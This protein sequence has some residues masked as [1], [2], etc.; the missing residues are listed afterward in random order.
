[1][2]AATL[3]QLTKLHFPWFKIPR[4]NLTSFFNIILMPVSED[5]PGIYIPPPLVYAAI[6]FLSILLQHTWPLDTSFFH[7]QT[8]TV[9]GI[10]FIIA[11]VLVNVTAIRQFVR[12]KNTIVTIKPANS[13]QTTG[14]YSRT[15]NPMYLGLV[16]FYTG[17]ALLTGNWWTLILLPF[18]VVVVGYSMIRPEE[19]YLER[20]FGNQFLEYKNKVRRWI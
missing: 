17:L 5:S 3:L 2:V 8:A 7:T 10:I 14:I 18:L 13:L 1:L 4:Q 15:R 20:R 19:K 9:A 6:F 12:S 16:L 11:F